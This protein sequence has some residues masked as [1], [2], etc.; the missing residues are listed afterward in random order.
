M[1]GATLVNKWFERYEIFA[2][3]KDNFRNN[4][5]KNF[6]SFDLLSKSYDALMSWAKPDVIVH[7]AAITNVDYCEENTDQTMAVNAESVKKLLKYCSDTRLIFIS[8]DSVFPDGVYLASEQDQTSPENIY[9]KSKEVGEKY[10]N[11]ALGSH[12]AIRT[13][14]VGENINPSKRGFLEW[15]VN[16]IKNG[17]EIT[18][19]DDAFFT[20]ITTWHLTNELEWIIENNI[21]GIIHIAGGEPISK[22]DF[23]MRI[24]EGLGLDTVLIKKGSIDDAQFNARRSKDQTMDS[25]YYLR[26]SNRVL[27]D[28]DQTILSIIQRFNRTLVSLN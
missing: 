9:G 8:S 14:I 19:F 12:L 25:C 7:C 18:L 28:M 15:I 3:G 27:P 17:K 1:L 23:G 24:C 21:S 5:A 20:P 16:S 6:M 22:Y 11:N 4:P 26:I 2:T 10:I 13:T